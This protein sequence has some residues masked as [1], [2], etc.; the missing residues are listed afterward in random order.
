MWAV[1]VVGQADTEPDIFSWDVPMG[2]G[3]LGMIRYFQ[4]AYAPGV[5]RL[6]DD[7]YNC[8]KNG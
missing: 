4:W 8:M 3:W 1:L 6:T 5:R 7:D 2:L